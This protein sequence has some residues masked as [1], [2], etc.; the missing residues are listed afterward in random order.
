MHDGHGR[1]KN[2]G[3]ATANFIYFIKIKDIVMRPGTPVLPVLHKD[4]TWGGHKI[5]LTNFAPGGNRFFPVSKNADTYGETV[6]KKL[7]NQFSFSPGV[8]FV[9][10][11][12]D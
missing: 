10:P 2:N 12:R 1:Q 5:K 7:F 6:C 9:S 4:T 8:I 3:T 11:V